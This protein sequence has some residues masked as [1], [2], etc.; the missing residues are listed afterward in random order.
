MHLHLL[1]L[2]IFFVI[3]L[4]VGFEETY[5]EIEEAF[6]KVELCV[7]ITELVNPDGTQFEF[8]LEVSTEK[9]TACE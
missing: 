7:N 2:F 8:Q 4:A 1:L 9:L 6:T 5:L 3:E